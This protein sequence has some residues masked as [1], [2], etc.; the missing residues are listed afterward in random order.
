M[1]LLFIYTMEKLHALHCQ[2]YAQILD[3]MTQI[4][5]HNYLY[6]STFSRDK[7]F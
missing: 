5:L 3:F 1:F 2:I 4:L 7:S 6:I